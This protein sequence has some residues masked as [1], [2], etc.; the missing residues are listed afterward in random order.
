[1]AE[2]ASF[3]SKNYIIPYHTI[4]LCSWFQKLISIIF[5][6]EVI[7]LGAGKNAQ[8]ILEKVPCDVNLSRIS[9]LFF[10]DFFVWPPGQNINECVCECGVCVCLWMCLSVCQSVFLCHCSCMS[11]FECVCW[12]VSVTLCRQWI[13]PYRKSTLLDSQVGAEGQIARKNFVTF[14]KEILKIWK[15]I[16]KNPKNLKKF[17]KSPKNLRKNLKKILKKFQKSQK[18]WKKSQKS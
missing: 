3:L 18:S 4:P 13:H 16:S 1:M 15:K 10:L 11:W 5:R 12:W 7:R 8:Q 17:F 6:C 14:F 9:Y 2:I